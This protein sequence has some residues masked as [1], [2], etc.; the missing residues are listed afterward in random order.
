MGEYFAF[1]GTFSHWLMKNHGTPGVPDEHDRLMELT[2]FLD[3]HI[4]SYIKFF[5]HT[6]ADDHTDNYYLEREWRV[7]G[8]VN[9]SIEDI[10]T[11]FMPKAFA[12]RFR[13]DFPLYSA[14]LVLFDEST[15]CYFTKPL[16]RLSRAIQLHKPVE[17]EKN[18]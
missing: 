16:T 12:R 13:A 17:G 10:E 11:I 15:E 14:Q 9:F 7:V 2:R 3:F 6:C 8:N 5:D 4:F 1:V 18:V